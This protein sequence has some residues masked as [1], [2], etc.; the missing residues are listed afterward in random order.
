MIDTPMGL[1]EAEEPDQPEPSEETVMA[2]DG[3]IVFPRDEPRDGLDDGPVPQ[4]AQGA[5]PYHVEDRPVVECSARGFGQACA[6][7]NVHLRYNERAARLEWKHSKVWPFQ[8]NT[9]NGWDGMYARL[10]VINAQIHHFFSFMGKKNLRPAKWPMNDMRH[11]AEAA[12]AAMSVDPFLEWV[13]HGIP[14]WDGVARLDFWLSEILDI[15]RRFGPDASPEDQ[16]AEDEYLAWCSRSTL[17]AAC[18][19]AETPGVKHDHMVVLVGPQGAGKSTAWANLFPEEFRAEWYGAG[20]DLTADAKKMIEA[21]QRRVIIEAS[22]FVT[23]TVT[24]ERVKSW[25]REVD[26][27]SVRMSFRRDPVNSPRRFV[28][29]GTSNDNACLP[30]DPSGNRTFSPVQVGDGDVPKLRAWLDEWREQLW[31]EAW[32]RRAEPAWMPKAME[33]AYQAETSDKYRRGREEQET[34]LDEYFEACHI[35]PTEDVFTL[36]ILIWTDE[37]HRRVAD[38]WRKN[39]KILGKILRGR[40]YEPKTVRVEGIVKRAWTPAGNLP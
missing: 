23:R 21:S 7:L 22:E 18:Q 25:L 6:Q 24:V 38:Q 2:E 17:L 1:M 33:L 4:F 32:E 3:T 5:S 37:H 29:V 15:Q 39:S 36:E 26:D 19:R 16:N 27:G 11:H 14:Q 31:A 12:A 30:N 20:L 35:L 34:V 8:E 40:G 10:P 28:A 9:G 13:Q